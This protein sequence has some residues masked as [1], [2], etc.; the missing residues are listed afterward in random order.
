MAYER[1]REQIKDQP[2]S[3]IIGQ[4]MP[5]SKRGSNHEGL[6]PFHGD[7]NPSLK[8]N[9]AKGMY[10]CFV[11][12]A[13]GDAITFVKEYKHVEFVDALKLIAGVMG[14]HFE[15]EQKKK[16]DPKEEMA[17][18][19]LN[20][21]V[22][23]YQKVAETGPQA[24]LA[25]V[26]KRKLTKESI[27]K[28]QIGYA[29]GGNGLLNYLQTIPA[30]DRDAALR[31]AQEIG[32]IKFNP[33]R[34]STYDFY[35]DRI[36]FPIH[37]HSGQVRGYSC[38]AV[39]EGQEPKYL[40]SGDSFIFHKAKILFGFCFGKNAIRTKDQVIIVEGNMDVIMM[41]QYGFDQTVGTMGTALSEYSVKLLSNMTKNVYLALDSDNAGKKAMAK[42]NAEFLR[43]GLLPKYL[44]FEPAKDPDEFLL[45]EGRFALEERIEKAPVL[46]DVMIA[47]LTKEKVEN[48]DHKLAILHKVFELVSP[49]KEHLSATERVVDAAKILGLRSDPQSIIED[50]KKYLSS[51]KERVSKPALLVEE[52]KLAKAEE[53]ARILHAEIREEPLGPLSA[54]ERVFLKEILCH[55]E[56]L[57]QLRPE[58]F[59]GFI[60]H[61]EVKKLI[62]WLV[63]I[64]SEI[65]DSEYV[66]I[67]MDELQNGVYGD[68][69]RSIGTDALFHHGNRYNDKVL[70][71]ML[72][73]YKL[74]LQN[75]QLKT[76][77]KELVARQRSS[78][79]QIEIDFILS[80]IAKIDKEIHSLKN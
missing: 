43:T 49:L 7:T 2:I 66:N 12:N 55:P 48:L 78:V 77:R 27:E 47:D 64:Y 38:R 61:V 21:S 54:S 5:L 67:V 26:E 15:E 18:R 28:Y 36:T 11:C 56:F 34:N 57:T 70:G 62:H 41:H 74:M 33:D 65:D 44:S 72:K 59:L 45:S 17:Q 73:D 63:S 3:F 19:V 13:G 6:C 80:E 16:K 58:E 1:L 24:Y 8:V 60:R 50:Y 4:F 10:K 29:P 53:E 46:L 40:N 76:R 31:V 51:L 79:T 75:D 25:F 35:R 30:S 52:E 68:E 20:A 39:L 71:R 42:I 9:D 37:D 23:L 69:V 32:M 14:W 22:R